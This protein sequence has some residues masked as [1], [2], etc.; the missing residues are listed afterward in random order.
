MNKIKQYVNDVQQ[1]LEK[2]S[3]PTREELVGTTGVVL[4]LCLLFSAFVFT[5]DFLLSKAIQ[6][7]F[8]L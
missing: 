2:V 4:V 7:F 1:E 8:S 3:W 5:M 6:A